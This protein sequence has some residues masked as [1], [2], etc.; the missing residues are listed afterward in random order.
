MFTYL[1]VQERLSDS[2]KTYYL[3]V[4]LHKKSSGNTE[5]QTV[6]SLWS[7]DVTTTTTTSTSTPKCTEARNGEAGDGD[8]YNLS[9]ACVC[10][11][12][13]DDGAYWGNAVSDNAVTNYAC[14]SDL[15]RPELS[16]AGDGL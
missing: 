16:V 12:R 11:T 10:V 8:G 14:V 3:Q 6:R 4:Q 2:L 13:R 9:G 1:L 7:H 15:P 5:R